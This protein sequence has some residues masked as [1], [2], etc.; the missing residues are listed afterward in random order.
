MPKRPGEK[1][2]FMQAAREVVE[3]AIGEQMDG[4]PLDIPQD[5]RDPH[6]VALGSEGGKKG[7]KARAKRLSAKRRSAIAKKAAN[8][9]WR[10][11]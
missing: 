7:G 3:K 9:R 11:K 10:K 2:D 4:S 1:R 5:T 6:F 8:S